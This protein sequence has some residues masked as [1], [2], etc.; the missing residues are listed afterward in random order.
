MRFNWKS[1]WLAT[2]AVSLAVLGAGCSGINSSHSISPATFLM[3]GLMQ[4]TPAR[5]L[6]VDLSTIVPAS[7]PLAQAN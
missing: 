4:T 3:P 1:V 7:Q 6:P 2:L 5:P